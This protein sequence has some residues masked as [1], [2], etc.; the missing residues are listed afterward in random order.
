MNEKWKIYWT[1][2]TTN[3]IND[4]NIM[5]IEKNM[6]LIYIDTVTKCVNIE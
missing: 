3:E 6:T 5:L 4:Y 2:D 1:S